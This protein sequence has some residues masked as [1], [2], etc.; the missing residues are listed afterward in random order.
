MTT[1]APCDE[2][3]DAWG[4]RRILDAVAR[5]DTHAQIRHWTAT[6]ESTL[7]RIL[8]HNTSH[9]EARTP[10]QGAGK[11][12][13]PRWFA[14]GP[15]A[16]LN[17]RVL[18]E[19]RAG[20]PDD[21]HLRDTYRR[22]INDPRIIGQPSFS[23]VAKA[24]HDKLAYTSKTLAGRAIERDNEACAIWYEWFTSKYH[25]DQ[26]VCVD[27]VS[28]DDRVANR[29]KGVSKLGK[30]ARSDSETFHRGRR[31]SGM[32]AFT[33]LDGFIKPFITEETFDGPR[34]LAGLRRCVFPFMGSYP[35]PRSV[36]LLDNAR[37]HGSMREII[38]ETRALGGRVEFLRAYDPE[39]MPIE[40]GFR[41]YKQ[42]RRNNKQ[43][44]EHETPR[45]AM[46]IAMMRVG[47]PAAARQA[48]HESGLM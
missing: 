20:A 32:C 31:Y 40:F 34:F 48:F 41:G 38:D 43:R 16:R 29:R 2:T 25:A 28:N 9:D 8:R 47:T 11:Q 35:G 24:L 15:N 33:V 4:A 14:A 12:N 26:I 5:G 23:C 21:E 30:R 17:L 27:E 37:I 45:E 18:E 6:S 36:L 1:A 13:D 19:I 46:R 7:R 22:L 10:V 3:V 39:H 44:Y 42:E